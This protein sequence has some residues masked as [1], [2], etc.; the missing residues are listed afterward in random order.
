MSGP[1]NI[2]VSIPRKES[3]D[4]V[5]G[6]AKYTDDTI[7]PGMLHAK[8][9]TSPYAHANIK[10]INIEAALKVKGVKSIITGDYCKVLFGA[11]V[12]DRP[13]IAEGKVRYFGEPVAMVV[14]NSEQEAMEAIELIKVEYEKLPA[15]NSVNEA[16]KTDAPLIHPDLSKYACVVDFANP[17]ENTNIASQIKIRKGD[18]A[19]AW[20]ESD[21]VVESSFTMPQSDH[22]AMETRNARVQILP[23]GHVII[24]TSSQ[25][26]FHVKQIISKKYNIPEGNLIVRVPFVGG[27]FGGKA[28]IQ[29]ETLAYLASK[30]VGGKMVKI[31]NTRE[32]DIRMSPC[33]IGLEASLKIGATK[34]GMIKALECTYLVDC[35]AYSDTAPTMAK[36]I[37]V[38]CTGPYNIENVYCDSFCVYTNH[39]FATSYRSFGHVS[40][41]FCIERLLDKLAVALGIDML[42]LRIKNAISPGNFSPTQ[43]KITQ[44]NT[45][46]L[47]RCLKKLKQVINWRPENIIETNGDMVHAKGIS[48]FWKTSDSP[49]N[50]T[51]G[52]ILT[53]NKDG[54]INLN[55]GAVEIGP[56][57]K[58]TAAQILAKRMNMDV[59]RIHVFMGVDTEVSPRHWKTVASMTTFMVGRAVLRA[60]EDLIKQLTKTASIA[61][62]CPEEDLEVSNEKVF[63]KDD[64]S[65]YI[66]F[67][68]LV[69]GFSYANGI[70]I[71]DQIIG[72]GSYVMRHITELNKETGKGKPGP[73]WTVGA[74]AVEIE[75][76]PKNYSYRILKA[77][78]V[79]DAGK[80]IN[81]KAAKGLIMGGMSMGLGLASR[82]EFLYDD[83]GILQNTS[84]RTYKPMHFGEN[85]EYIVD[86]IETPQ[87][88]GPYGAR[89]LGEHG[90]IGIP[91]AFA[92]ALSLAA[93]SDFLKIPITPE[94]IWQTKTGG[95]YD[96]L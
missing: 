75:Y 10:S 19:K 43:V 32:E 40:F 30:S 39:T 63:L 1:I 45:G 46:C 25:A 16:I 81:P 28:C 91:A 7:I 15:I 68:D 27:G 35:G 86:F 24:Y 72:R 96:T 66:A 80:I 73:S 94:V 37:A 61:M 5:T 62:K 26:P 14:A 87:I 54:S 82:E 93:E 56:G 42:E 83:E 49:S 71:G 2:G 85:P 34:D 4:K 57:M 8:L 76:N 55:C 84:L 21:V 50:A 13:P 78:T 33:K 22:L 79:I 60:A 3:L 58:T 70:A 92:T 65:I 11:N 74:Q 17:K 29:L 6:A 67:K 12:E 18:M 59:S 47:Q 77:V 48:C 95:K 38:N 20:L 23:D 9:L 53:F 69:Y 51:S 41:T 90:I 64:P 88:D 44:S 36:A 52:A 89:G 31:A